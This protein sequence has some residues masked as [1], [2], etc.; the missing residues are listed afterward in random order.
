MASNWQY[1][2]NLKVPFES[3]GYPNE[4]SGVIPNDTSW[5]TTSSTTINLPNIQ[6]YFRD[7]NTYPTSP[8]YTAN[9]SRVVIT[10]SQ[11][12]TTTIGSDNVVHATVTGTINSIVRDDIQGNPNLGGTAKRNIYIRQYKGGPVIAEFDNLNIATAETIGSN[13][14]LP[15][16]TI[17]LQPGQNLSQ[18]SLYIVNCLPGHEGDALPSI[19]VDAMLMGV[20]VMNPLPEPPKDY[21]PGMT[22][23]GTAFMSHN[24]SNGGV[25]NYWNGSDWTEMRTQ[26]YPDGKGNPPLMYR[27][28]D[29]YNQA[30]IGNEQSS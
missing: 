30:L 11:R 27:D 25:C 21:R 28:G 1:R 3:G 10:V 6:Y 4:P 2:T 12:I 17:T 19:N 22:W 24:R 26:D 16:Y 23:N 9:S 8:P 7:A 20:E 14:T 5:K 13:I 18:Y 29:W 15:S